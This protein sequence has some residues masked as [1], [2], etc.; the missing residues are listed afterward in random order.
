MEQDEE[1]DDRAA[2]PARQRVDVRGHGGWKEDE[3]RR[4][5][6]N[7]AP[8]E[9]SEHREEDAGEDAHR[10]ETAVREDVALGRLHARFAAQ[11]AENAQGKVGFGGGRDVA[12]M[13]RGETPASVGLL[14]A[15]EVADHRLTL[16]V[17]VEAKGLAHEHVLGGD[18][19]VRLELR[20]PVP[21]ASLYPSRVRAG[22][23]HRAR[24]TPVNEFG[25]RLAVESVRRRAVAVA[26][27]VL[28]LV[29]PTAV[30]VPSTVASDRSLRERGRT[31]RFPR[32]SPTPRI[33]SREFASAAPRRFPA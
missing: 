12:D 14:L 2:R 9:K 33:R 32:A 11:D 26:R 18:G 3:F 16:R 20:A 4:Q 13:V 31:R 10:R 17:E 25:R 30:D 5:A 27:G 6:R 1:R 19:R 7:V 28:H 24:S 15:E 29:A 21:V 23:L 22:A 8:G